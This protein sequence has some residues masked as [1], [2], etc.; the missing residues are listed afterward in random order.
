M[1]VSDG[2]RSLWEGHTYDLVLEVLLLYE[3]SISSPTGFSSLVEVCLVHISMPRRPRLGRLVR[4][5]SSV[6]LPC[7][8]AL[9]AS[10]SRCLMVRFET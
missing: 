5:P 1:R 4:N 6:G 9:M 7:L 2:W 8:F 10:S 3:S